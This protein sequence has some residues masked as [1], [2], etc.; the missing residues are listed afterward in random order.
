MELATASYCGG[1]EGGSGIWKGEGVAAA[2]MVATAGCLPAVA[3][4]DFV[5]DNKKQQQQQ[6]P[7]SLSDRSVC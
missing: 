6:Q 2:V 4:C 1:T 7:K 3:P 5:G